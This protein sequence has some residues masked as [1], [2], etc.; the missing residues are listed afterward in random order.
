M[1]EKNIL[2]T[3]SSC[4]SGYCDLTSITALHQ[5]PA[6]VAMLHVLIGCLFFSTSFN[7]IFWPVLP[8]SWPM[9][10]RHQ[11]QRHDIKLINKQFEQR[12]FFVAM[13]KN[14]LFDNLWVFYSSSD[15][16]QC[17]CTQLATSGDQLQ[18]SPVSS[19]L[20]V[21]RQP[22]NQ[23][24]SVQPGSTANSSLDRWSVSTIVASVHVELDCFHK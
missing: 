2:H 11:S 3:Y 8:T 16:Y 7:I 20:V 17:A 12:A 6:W 9:Y 5:L 10:M 21:T 14:R 24:G 22:I 15:Y 1:E 23:S 18:S 19:L 13:P 4:A